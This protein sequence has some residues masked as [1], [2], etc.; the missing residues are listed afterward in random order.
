MDR[1]RRLAL[2]LRAGAP[3]HLDY[4]R[5]KR[6]PWWR[7]KEGLVCYLIER[8]AYED[9]SRLH[10]LRTSCAQGYPV[11]FETN[12]KTVS[13]GVNVEFAKKVLADA[14]RAVKDAHQIKIPWSNLGD[15][16]SLQEADKAVLEAEATELIAAWQAAFGDDNTSPEGKHAG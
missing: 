15:D 6:E 4:S 16:S 8:E 2:I 11:S 12:G 7:L 13:G 10:V 5:L 1:E 9:V 3:R 14:M